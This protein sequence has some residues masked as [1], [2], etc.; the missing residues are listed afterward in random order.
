MEDSYLL[1][2]TALAIISIA[3]LINYYDLTPRVENIL[4]GEFCTDFSIIFPGCWCAGEAEKLH[5]FE[6]NVSNILIAKGLMIN[7]YKS[8]NK[9]CSELNCVNLSQGFYNCFCE[10]ELIGT[11]SKTGKFYKTECGI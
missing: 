5:D 2:I 6:I 11:L 3:S 10:Q 1:L 9:S 7:Y 8:V 4:T